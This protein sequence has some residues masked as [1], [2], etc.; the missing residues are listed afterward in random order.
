MLKITKQ[1][2]N[3]VIASSKELGY[4]KKIEGKTFYSI[5]VVPKPKHPNQERTEKIRG[6]GYH[7]RIIGQEIWARK[8]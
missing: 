8:K 2:V 4:T 5:G 1:N 3:K 7:V 6:L